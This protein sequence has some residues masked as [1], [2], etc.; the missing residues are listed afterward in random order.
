MQ[1]LILRFTTGLAGL[2]AGCLLLSGAAVAHQ[3]PAVE[4]SV[5]IQRVEVPADQHLQLLRHLALQQ[6]VQA[7]KAAVQQHSM[8]I[9]R[10][11]WSPEQV[12]VV[13]HRLVQQRE[14]GRRPSM[15]LEQVRVTVPRK[16]LASTWDVNSLQKELE[17]LG[18]KVKPRPTAPKPS[19]Q[20][21]G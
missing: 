7:V 13:G 11:S 4:R 10:I 14:Q 6:E 20:L 3:R 17:R 2:L 18:I 1:N 12:V 16:M 8:K 9:S 21:A 19:G 15:W 5:V